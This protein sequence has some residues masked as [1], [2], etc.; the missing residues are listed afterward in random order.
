MPTNKP[1]TD[2][3][4]G[5]PAQWPPSCWVVS[6]GTPGTENQSLGLAEAMGLTP[7]IKRL[8]IDRISREAN[9]QFGMAL[10]AA[11]ARDAILPPWPDMMIATGRT[12]LVASRYVKKANGEGTFVVQIQK[13]VLNPRMFDCVVVPEHDELSGTNVIPMIGGM[14]RVS[15]ELLRESTAKWAPTFAHLPRPLLAVLLG[16]SNRAVSP[17]RRLSSYHLGRNEITELATKLAALARDRNA[18]LLITTS[19]RTGEDNVALLREL[20]RDTPAMIWSGEGNNPYYGMLGAADALFVTCDSV[21][22]ISEACSTGKPVHMIQLP[23]YSRKRDRFHQ[24]LYDLGCMRVFTGALEHWT[25]EPLRERE[26]VAV[27]VREA[28]ERAR[29]QTNPT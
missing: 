11:L 25:Y 19:R 21:N 29:M 12:S 7:V 28:Y 5:K 10:R 13:P 23:G 27:L 24:K 9:L 8:K 17:L 14:H 4:S 3:A 6:D 2:I 22:M 16:G 18:G 15:P 26:R 20:L 1:Q